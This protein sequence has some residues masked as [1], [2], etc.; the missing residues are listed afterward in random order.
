[1]APAPELVGTKYSSAI[2]QERDAG[3]WVSFK[4]R[5]S[6][7]EK[8]FM[9]SDFSTTQEFYFESSLSL[10]QESKLSVNS[11]KVLYTLCEHP[12]YRWTRI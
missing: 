2:S 9:I 1:M 3:Q 8:K 4:S 11:Q 6:E 7:E 5:S 12:L 10:S